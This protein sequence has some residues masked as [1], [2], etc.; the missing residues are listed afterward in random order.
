MGINKT[1]KEEKASSE[2]KFIIEFFKNNDFNYSFEDHKLTKLKGDTKEWRVPDFYLKNYKVYVEYFGMYN[3]NKE[4]RAEYDLKRD[5]YFKNDIPVIILHPHQ[6]GIIEYAFHVGMLKTLKVKKFNLGKQLFL[7]R[8]KRFI[9]KSAGVN[10][11]MIAFFVFFR[12]SLLAY[13]TG[14][15]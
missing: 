2:E 1:K 4:T 15:K 14:L 10:F 6:L 7:Y 13:D 11:A 3:H 9:S 5:V 12:Y 8:L